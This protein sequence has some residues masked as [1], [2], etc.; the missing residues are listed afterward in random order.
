MKK[1][2]N[3]YGYASKKLVVG[4][5]VGLGVA[6]AAV[7]VFVLTQFGGVDA[8]ITDI[9]LG[10]YGAS[11]SSSGFISADELNAQLELASPGGNLENALYTARGGLKVPK[12]SGNFGYGIQAGDQQTAVGASA[13][14]GA[15]QQ[16]SAASAGGIEGMGGMN[17]GLRGVDGEV[18]NKV[19]GA[20][21]VQNIGNIAGGIQGGQG[22]ERGS[23]NSLVTSQTQSGGFKV[24]GISSSSGGS[25]RLLTAQGGKQSSAGAA[26][27]IPG[28]NVNTLVARGMGRAG[29]IGGSN[30]GGAGSGGGLGAG[31]S[32]AGN[33]MGALFR[34]ST[35]SSK[36]AAEGDFSKKE[37]AA[38]AAFD[39]STANEGVEIAEDAVVNSSGSPNMNDISSRIGRG[40]IGRDIAAEQELQRR[41]RGKMDK[42]IES[43]TTHNTWTLITLGLAKAWSR[44]TIKRN[45][46]RMFSGDNSVAG[47]LREIQKLSNIKVS[48][49]Q[50]EIAEFFFFREFLYMKGA[51]FFGKGTYSIAGISYDDIMG[52][53]GASAE[54]MYQWYEDQQK[55]I[56]RDSALNNTLARLRAN[57]GRFWNKII[58]VTGAN[59][60]KRKEEFEK[61]NPDRIR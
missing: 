2:F 21:G 19:S 6:T 22:G 44:K 46:D 53:Y 57:R 31:Q 61:L 59:G 37:E 38:A 52:G 60:R 43:A 56:D 3:K 12:G 5:G 28:A 8:D 16:L 48:K 40:G 33:L 7:G 18:I 14:A 9:A 42:I 54:K 11:D 50:Y 17:D 35:L 36:A 20:R 55:E 4:M 23:K 39:N 26:A 58:E 25:V 10:Q 49:A 34:A 47:L 41:I 32:G 29:A 24:T 45:F 1:L 51:A 27:N 13:N 30:V 15:Q